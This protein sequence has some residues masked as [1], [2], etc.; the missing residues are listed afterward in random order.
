MCA[1]FRVQRKAF[2]LTELCYNDYDRRRKGVDM[3]G[4]LH[5]MIVFA[6]GISD[7]KTLL[8]YFEFYPYLTTFDKAEFIDTV[9]TYLDAKKT[10]RYAN[11]LKRLFSWRTGS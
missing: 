9:Y 2:I 5:E 7:V 3:D 6:R 8:R 4:L 1:A 10:K 11:K